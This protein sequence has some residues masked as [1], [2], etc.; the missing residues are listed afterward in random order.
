MTSRRKPRKEYPFCV[1][2][3]AGAVFNCTVLRFVSC[4]AF[5]S[6]RLYLSECS[7]SER[8]SPQLVVEQLGS[9]VFLEVPLSII[10]PRCDVRHFLAIHARW[11]SLL[12]VSPPKSTSRRKSRS[13][14][15]KLQPLL[16]SLLST[17]ESTRGICHL[18]AADASCLSRLVSGPLVQHTPKHD[19]REGYCQRYP[20]TR[21]H[22]LWMTHALPS[23]TLEAVKHGEPLAPN[24][25][26][27]DGALAQLG[28]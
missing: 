6:H 24:I 28:W 4:G 15:W 23:V 10:Q 1:R 25:L 16:Q 22:F 26:E 2:S 18:E 9:D 7:S 27:Y 21:Q 17:T 14:C 20:L 12:E 5:R 8:I 13:T 19:S 11:M 3:A